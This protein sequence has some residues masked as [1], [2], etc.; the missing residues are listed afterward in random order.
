MV[1]TA[2]ATLAVLPGDGLRIREMSRDVERCREMS[3]DVER[4]REMLRVTQKEGI[5]LQMPGSWALS[6]PVSELLAQLV[7]RDQAYPECTSAPQQLAK[8]SQKFELVLRI[9]TS[10]QQLERYASLLLDWNAKINLMSREIRDE[11]EILHRHVL[12]LLGFQ[13]CKCLQRACYS[14]LF[15]KMLFAFSGSYEV[16]SDSAGRELSAG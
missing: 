7:G 15:A 8:A 10:R 13:L 2:F 6:T 1:L 9:A 4:C 5:E 14:H 12:P 3:R 16:C 11:P